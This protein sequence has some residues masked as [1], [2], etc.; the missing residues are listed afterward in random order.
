MNL[1]EVNKGLEA[2]MQQYNIHL[3]NANEAQ[4]VSGKI[5]DTWAKLADNA[6]VTASDLAKAN[7]QSASAAY[8]AGV[9]FD[10][11]NAMIAT[12]SGATGKAG[13]EIGRSIRSMLVSMNTAKAEK[14]L[15]K[16]GIATK[17]IGT[18]GVMRIRSFENVITDL[19]VKLKTY[20][21]DV[22]KVIL[23]MSGGRRTCPLIWEH[24]SNK[25]FYIG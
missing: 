16:L 21:N 24:I 1:V 22:S 11:L 8:Q 5:V 4:E 6:V 20:P 7:E 13:A 19:M 25:W 9:G 18:D 3:K 14:E 15:A 23:A 2:T 10:F 17:E 12:M